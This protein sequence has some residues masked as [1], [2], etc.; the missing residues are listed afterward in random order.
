MPFDYSPPDPYWKL[1]F[2]KKLNLFVLAWHHCIGDGLTGNG[3]LLSLSSSLNQ[4]QHHI[5]NRTVIRAPRESIDSPLEELTELTVSY[6][7]VIRVLL[8]ILLPLSW[9][10]PGFW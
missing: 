4:P 3:F 1:I 2:A 7:T 5:E 10:L 9:T 6:S 8:D